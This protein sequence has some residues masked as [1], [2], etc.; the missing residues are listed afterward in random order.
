MGIGVVELITVVII[1]VSVLVAL[2]VT[3][4]ATVVPLFVMYKVFTG[5][6]N[7]QGQVQQV[8]V[9]GKHAVAKVQQIWET[10]MTMRVGMMGPAG[11]QGEQ[12]Q[13]GMSLEVIPFESDPY[14]TQL[15]A[16]VPR[17]RI[18]SLQPGMVIP[19]KYDPANPA[20]V[21]IDWASTEWGAS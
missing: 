13:V 7:N 15:T 19:V 4:V 21:A 3:L 2:V 8:L 10:G 9:N 20:L 17:L 1:L 12:I 14:Q 18:P 5:I 16:L 11:M 6:S